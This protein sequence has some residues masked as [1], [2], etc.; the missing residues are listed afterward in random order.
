VFDTPIFVIVVIVV[1]L[2]AL[3][4]GGSGAIHTNT[5]KTHEASVNA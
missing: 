2:T 1:V 4:S 5:M 3:R